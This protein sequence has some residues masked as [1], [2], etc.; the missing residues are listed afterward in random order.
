MAW[1]Q[2]CANVWEPERPALRMKTFTGPKYI[3]SPPG[4]AGA[5]DVASDER[6]HEDRPHPQGREGRA[7]SGG[8][9]SAEIQKLAA[10]RKSGVLARDTT[11]G[12]FRILSE[13]DLRTAVPL[14]ETTRRKVDE[15]SLV[16]TQI[17][18]KTVKTKGKAGASRSS[19]KKDRF[20]GFNP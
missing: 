10:G 1:L 7:R 6:P 11:T 20:G 2:A 4:R 19:G 16:D 13:A 18:R 5:R 3:F 15:L 9:T 14:T 8:E 12:H 17:L